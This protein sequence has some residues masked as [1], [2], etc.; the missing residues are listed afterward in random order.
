MHEPHCPTAERL[1]A[2]HSPHLKIKAGRMWRAV[3]MFHRDGLSTTA[4]AEE[5]GVDEREV[6]ELIDEAGWR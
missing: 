3:E 5:L 1:F 6:C 4:I 2:S